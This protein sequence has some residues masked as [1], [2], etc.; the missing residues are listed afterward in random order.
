MAVP[1]SVDR[2]TRGLDPFIVKTQDLEKLRELGRGLHS[3][4]TSGKLNIT[5]KV[6]ACVPHRGGVLAL[7][8]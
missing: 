3:V 5:A 1:Q 8:L 7:C 2:H 4:V 6:S